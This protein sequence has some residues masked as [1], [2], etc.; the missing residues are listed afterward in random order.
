M[1]DRQDHD[2]LGVQKEEDG[3]GKSTGKRPAQAAVNLGILAWVL[4][5][6]DEVFVDN[7]QKLLPETDS[8]FLVPT[9]RLI[10][11]SLGGRRE[12]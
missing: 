2:G 4:D 3:V 11:V 10:E 7:R 12:I 6:T 9:K 1:A 5:E 8:L